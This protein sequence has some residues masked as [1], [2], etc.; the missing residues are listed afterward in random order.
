MLGMSTLIQMLIPRIVVLCVLA[1]S[2]E[3]L[4]GNRF[5]LP[6]QTSTGLL[7]SGR[8]WDFLHESFLITTADESSTRMQSTKG[9]LSRLELDKITL[10]KFAVDR[11]DKVRGCY[12]SHMAVLRE[13]SHAMQKQNR[14]SYYVL[15]LEDNIALAYENSANQAVLEAL[16]SI[17]SFL[18]SAAV[19]CDVLHL[20]YMMYVPGLRAR[21]LRQEGHPGIVQLFSTS[22]ATAI[23]TSAYFISAQGVQ[24]LLQYDVAQGGYV[25]GKAIPNVMA[26]VFP[27]S[28][29]AL[30]PMLLHRSGKRRVLPL[31]LP[32]M[33]H[34]VS[35]TRSSST[36]RH[37]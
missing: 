13:V 9:V 3:A 1:Y 10:K 4:L 11:E 5:K 8:S 31:S 25:P 32:Y 33:L 34:P 37:C 26:E 19:T 27:D 14:D 22:N 30:Y 28:R 29:Y 23:G 36:K 7:L 15:M 20:G 24:K 12:T 2:I 6:L 21:S 35:A 16:Q 18:N 17:G